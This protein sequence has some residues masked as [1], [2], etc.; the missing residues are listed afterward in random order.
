MQR[1]DGVDAGQTLTITQG[2]S[3]APAPAAGR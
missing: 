1:I 2:A 3:V